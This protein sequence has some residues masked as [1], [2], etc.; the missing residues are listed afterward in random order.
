LWHLYGWLWDSTKSHV[1]IFNRHI[2]NTSLG[3]CCYTSLIGCV[4]YDEWVK[5]S[6]I[7]H[8]FMWNVFI[9]YLLIRWFMFCLLSWIWTLF[10]CY[11][12]LAYFSLSLQLV[13][14]LAH[15]HDGVYSLQ[16]C[17]I[18]EDSRFLGCDTSAGR[19][20]PHVLKEGSAF[21]FNTLPSGGSFGSK[22]RGQEQ[23]VCV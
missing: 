20:I 18:W 7:L 22:N 10:F 6:Q 2:T 15:L 13:S 23:A 14:I 12:H 5:T 9:I 19:V 21:I 17:Q 16:K 1:G 4:S 3:C 11:P 8:P